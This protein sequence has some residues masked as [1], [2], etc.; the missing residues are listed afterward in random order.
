[1]GLYAYGGTSGGETPV[2]AQ[3]RI[4]GPGMTGASRG[5]GGGGAGIG[6]IGWAFAESSNPAGDV[7]GMYAECRKYPISH[8]N[9]FCPAMEL[10]SANITGS[11][12][13]LIYPYNFFTAG[14]VY[15]AD[16][17]SGGQCGGGGYYCYDPGTGLSNLSASPD[18][19]AIGVLNNGAPHQAGIVFESLSIS[20]TDGS[21]GSGS[22]VAF[23]MARG[24]MMNWFAQGNSQKFIF[25]SVATSGGNSGRL[26]WTDGGLELSSG[27][28][29][30][31]HMPTTGSENVTCSSDERLKEDIKPYAESA[32]AYF[33]SFVI[34]DYRV[35]ATGER[36]VGPIAQEVG[37][38]HPE[39]V[40]LGEDNMLMVQQP[41]Q[42]TFVVAIQEL[43]SQVRLLW[44]AL[45][46][47]ALALAFCI[48]R[49]RKVA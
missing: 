9:H 24:Q 35:K 27:G 17:G 39:L 29:S 22:G 23:A 4:G 43:H 18:S 1:V 45:G 2:V 30:C 46:V 25:G 14:K 36:A 3:S 40:S 20:G 16:F 8:P 34:H 15:T 47:M 31:T 21:D 32:L 7:W 19:Y 10:E 11:P 28:A 44:A 33:D 48:Y 41:N 37:L 12:S 13:P 6:V 38:K 49:T 26:Q 42:W 5:S